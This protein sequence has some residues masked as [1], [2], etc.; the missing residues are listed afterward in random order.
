MLHIIFAIVKIA[1]RAQF[2][3]ACCGRRLQDDGAQLQEETEM[4]RPVSYLRR[5]GSY[6][7]R[8]R[9]E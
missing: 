9:K 3:I 5:A 6:L 1:A 2:A 8:T 4:S 7:L